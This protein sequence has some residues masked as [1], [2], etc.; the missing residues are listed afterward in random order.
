[1]VC[2][3]LWLTAQLACAATGAGPKLSSH[4]CS[5]HMCNATGMLKSVYWTSSDTNGSTTSSLRMLLTTGATRWTSRM[6]RLFPPGFYTD[7]PLNP[8]APCPERTDNL[9][10][11][12]IAQI[13]QCNRH[14]PSHHLYTTR[15]APQSCLQ[16]QPKYIPNQLC[17]QIRQTPTRAMHE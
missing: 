11:G 15:K 12:P 14:A 1:M 10:A 16:E 8:S 13:F 2:S 9:G 3:R 5:F 4:A 6:R 17:H 7:T